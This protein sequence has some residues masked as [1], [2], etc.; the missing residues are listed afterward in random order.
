MHQILFSPPLAAAFGLGTPELIIVGM[1][2]AFPV[3]VVAI[4]ALAL[5]F[6]HRQRQMWHETARLALEK[7]QPLPPMPGD[8]KSRA[9]GGP[10][11]EK[12]IYHDVRGGL[13][14]IAVG[15]A[16]WLTSPPHGG[17]WRVIGAVPLFTGVALLL[18]ALLRGLMSLIGN[19][20]KNPPPRT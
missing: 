1:L 3:F 5:S 12:M 6:K 18:F 2:L 19:R 11:G 17:G 15:A 4:V 16:L 14:L 8:D 7:G 10:G 13:V 9:A 20:G